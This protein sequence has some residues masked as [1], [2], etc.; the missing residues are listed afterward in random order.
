MLGSRE[1]THDVID[2]AEDLWRHGAGDRDTR[3]GVV[4]VKVVQ[5]APLNLQKAPSIKEGLATNVERMAS[6]IQKACTTGKKPALVGHAQGEAEV[7][8]PGAGPRNAAP[9]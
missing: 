1:V 3:G 2:A 7:H 6:W 5:N 8:D 4:V 9:R